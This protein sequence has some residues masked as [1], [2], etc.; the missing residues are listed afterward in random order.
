VEDS[1][2]LKLFS[3]ALCAWQNSLHHEQ[4]LLL[5]CFLLVLLMSGRGYVIQEKLILQVVRIN[6]LGS[7]EASY[8]LKEE[9]L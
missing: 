5:M 2:S 9:Q 4:F 1:T 3:D 6:T 8:Y 7:C